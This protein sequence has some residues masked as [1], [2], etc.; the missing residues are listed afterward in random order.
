MRERAGIMSIG[1]GDNANASQDYAMALEQ[2]AKPLKMRPLSAIKRMQKDR[3]RQ[4]VNS[5]ALADSAIA[6]GQGNK[7]NGADAIAGVM[8]ASRVA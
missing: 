2:K 3:V 4:T 7:A 6:I 8:V 5:Q 1:L